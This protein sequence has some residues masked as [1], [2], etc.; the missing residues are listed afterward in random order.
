MPA[1]TVTILG[2]PVG[3]YTMA[4]L[5]ARLLELIAAPGCAVA[6]GI[7]AHVFNLLYRHPDFLE[8]LRR[9]DLLYA[10][11]ASVRL[12]AR[13]LG[14]CIPE[15][16]TTTDI[17]PHLCELAETQGY[18]FFLLGGEPGLAPRARARAVAQYPQLQ[19][20]GVHHG[21]FDLED[22]SVIMA[23]NAAQPDILWVGMGDPRQVLWADKWRRH[24]QVG[25]VLTCGGMFKIVAGELARLPEQWRRRGCEW[26][27]RLWQEPGTWRRYL[28]GL[29]LF[30]LRVLAQRFLGSRAFP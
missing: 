30:G 18:R 29:P 22:E 5:L 8:A 21:Y 15:K 27:Y 17:W 6:Y 9:A 23:I 19:I 26:L 13:I 7:N 12:A 1:A 24:L 2:L 10:D 28:L 25:L 11:G 20:A 3:A 4:S 14:G 16:L